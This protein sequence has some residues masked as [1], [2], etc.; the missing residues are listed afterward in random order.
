MEG[1]YA[2]NDPYN[3]KDYLKTVLPT[4]CYEKR[5]VSQPLPNDKLG[6]KVSFIT[7][8]W[9]RRERELHA[10][11]LSNMQSP[12]KREIDAHEFAFH[13]ANKILGCGKNNKE[14]ALRARLEKVERENSLMAKRLQA[15]LKA[16]RE[17]GATSERNREIRARVTR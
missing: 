2:L 13:R 11:S 10:K 14:K 3:V 17:V 15:V 8:N 7:R 12:L 9:R 16:P 5:G 1:E 4:S 6:I